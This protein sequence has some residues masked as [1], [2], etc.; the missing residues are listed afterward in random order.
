MAHTD[1]EKKLEGTVIVRGEG[2]GF[3]QTI[4]AGEH[5]YLS[6]EP[7]S[8]G[9][10]DL[11]PSPYDL[12]LSALGACTS[13]TMAMYARRKQWPLD[14]VTIHLRHSRV[15]ADDCVSCESGDVALTVIDRDIAIEG[16]L[17]QAQRARLLEIAN[18]CPVH[19]TLTSTTITVRTRLI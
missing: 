17:D 15:H 6:D 9:G 16:S 4:I 18:R 12:L 7:P 5:R 14:R 19:R 3:A 11:G 2:H 1:G 8:A 10:T 13:M